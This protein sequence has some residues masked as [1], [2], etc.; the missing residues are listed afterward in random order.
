M[1]SYNSLA[2]LAP[3]QTSLLFSKR[4]IKWDEQRCST[5]APTPPALHNT[6]ASGSLPVSDLLQ[7]S[8]VAEEKHW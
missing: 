7:N 2:T 5:L 3:P 8:P 4:L 1:F 6:R